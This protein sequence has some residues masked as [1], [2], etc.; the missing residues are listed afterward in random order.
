MI[1]TKQT[2]L[3]QALGGEDRARHIVDLFQGNPGAGSSQLQRLIHSSFDMDRIDYL[4]R[5]ARATGVPYGIVDIDYLLSHVKI[6]PEGVVGIE[7]KALAAVEHFVLARFFMHKAVY[8]HKT[9]YGFE[10]C[11]R[12]LLRRAS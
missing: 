7:R 10:E 9:T 11:C 8:Y 4:L 3:V 6:S 12:Q 1:V 5:D 2:G